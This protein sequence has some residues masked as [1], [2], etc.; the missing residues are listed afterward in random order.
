MVSGKIRRIIMNV[1][2]RP[3]SRSLHKEM[4]RFIVKFSA[5]KR[6]PPNVKELADAFDLGST[7]TVAYHLNLMEEQGLI[8][9]K[10][11]SPRTVVVT[12]EGE[13]MA[14]R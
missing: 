6:Y 3:G 2:R 9:R 5:E 11:R 8:T 14:G 13:E 10:P 12:P 1:K 7:S 4:I